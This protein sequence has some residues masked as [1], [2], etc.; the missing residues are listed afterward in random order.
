MKKLLS[1][2]AIIEVLATLCIIVSVGF[3]FW[4][5]QSY[6]PIQEKLNSVTVNQ[7]LVLADKG[8]Y[9]LLSSRDNEAQTLLIFYPGAKVQPLSY[10]YN[11]SGLVST[12]VSIAITKPLF[13]YAFF[14]INAANQIIQS[15]FT[16][17][18]FYLSGHSL[19]GAMACIF[20]QRNSDKLDGMILLASYC[21]NDI[22]GSNL[23]IISLVGSRDGLLEMETIAENKS[24]L[25]SQAKLIVIEGMNHA[26]FGSYG[27]QSGDLEATISDQEAKD[28]VNEKILEF[29]SNQ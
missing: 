27:R 24:N 6:P 29:I 4:F 25:G 28:I 7:D 9:W 23:E 1:K 20:A 21:D 16:Y 10:V 3:G 22:S 13:N 2:K 18:Q 8:G 14:D 19:G 15:E 5:F 12:S 11:L 26:Q 17:S